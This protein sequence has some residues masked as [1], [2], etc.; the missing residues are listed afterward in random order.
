M[1]LDAQ[2]I[3]ERED[4][5][6]ENEKEVQLRLAAAHLAGPFNKPDSTVIEYL[7]NADLIYNYLLEGTKPN[8]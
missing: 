2:Q 8:Q 6:D 1:S 7:D 5:M 4:A 3:E